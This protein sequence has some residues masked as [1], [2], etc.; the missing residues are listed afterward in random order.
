MEEMAP[1][2][3]GNEEAGVEAGGIGQGLPTP[4]REEEVFTGA[5]IPSKESG[6]YGLR[7][8]GTRGSQ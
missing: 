8:S 2:I 7:P 4:G 5:V 1:G 6:G 3:S